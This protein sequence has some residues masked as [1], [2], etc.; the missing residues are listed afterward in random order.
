MPTATRDI[1]ELEVL[2]RS[3]AALISIASHEE[4]RV[5]ALLLQLSIKVQKPFFR[6]TVT[7]GLERMDLQSEPQGFTTEPEQVL[8]H[9]KALG[10]P[11]IFALMDFHPYMA[12]PLII[13]HLK[14]I[15]LN[16]QVRHRVVLV[17][18][19]LDI[20]ADLARY[21]AQFALSIP[22]A[23]ELEQLVR[24]EARQW[25]RSNTDSRIV[26]ERDMLNRVVSSLQGLPLEDARRLA[27]GAI[28]DDG[29]LNQSDLTKI[30]KEKFRLLSQD[31][32]LNFEHDSS[33]FADIGGLKKLKEWLALRKDAFLGHKPELKLDAPKGVLLLGVQGCGKSLAAK[34]VAGVWGLPLLHLDFG[35]LYNRF[36]GES[37]RNIR[38]SLKTTEAMA[39][40]VL[41]IDEIEK[42]ISADGNDGGTS[43]RVFGTFL[44]WLAE[45]KSRVFIVATA[46]EIDSLPPELIRKGRLD[47]IFFVDLPSPAVR[48][49]IL[50][51]HLRRRD[52]S[53]EDFDLAAV[54]ARADG[55]S[56][57]E[58]EQ[59]IVSALYSVHAQASALTTEHLLGELER[60]QPLSIVMAERIGRLRNWAGGRTVSAD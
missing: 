3:A 24:D 27:R 9:I 20:P 55:Y 18:H 5:L 10:M 48:E 33:Q 46:N 58:L 4:N 30:Q 44:T 17:S 52:L 8:G 21:C 54:A 35:A 49:A 14:D 50:A 19:A 11:G 38:E 6:W 42:G 13:R 1:H 41:W 37:E 53:P 7:T 34:A 22:S 51:I 47:E 43:R 26:T 28:A 60:T 31:G 23:P 32:V 45:K 29:R 36:Y 12:E 56:G 39:P 25:A 40:C 2:L 59:V 16:R 57:A 15:A